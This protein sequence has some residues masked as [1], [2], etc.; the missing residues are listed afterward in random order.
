MRDYPNIERL[1][2]IPFTSQLPSIYEV[3]ETST[4]TAMPD[5]TFLPPSSLQSS[6]RQF[7]ISGGTLHFGADVLS[8]EI[9]TAD[10]KTIATSGRRQATL[11]RRG[12]YIVRTTTKDGKHQTS[13][14]IM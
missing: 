2:F 1:H 13:K 5:V 11:P 9:F 7:G 4:D 12:I 3:K 10:G 6:D 8:Y 14:V